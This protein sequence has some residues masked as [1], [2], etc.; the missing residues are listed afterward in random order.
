MQV[1]ITKEQLK[2][3]NAKAGCLERD[4]GQ[5]FVQFVGRLDESNGLY[6]GTIELATADAEQTYEFFSLSEI[7]TEAKHGIVHDSRNSHL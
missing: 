6:H 3:L 7:L 4:S 1:A 2:K 5:V